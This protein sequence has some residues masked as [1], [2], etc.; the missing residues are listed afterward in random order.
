MK[1]QYCSDLHLEFK[2]NKKFLDRHPVEP[3]GEILLLAGDIVPFPLI[4]QHS[5]FFDSVSANYERVYW[6]PGNH[7]YY[8]YDISK[9]KDQLHEKIRDNV[10][11]VNNNT[12][13][14]KNVNFIFTTLW[15]HIGP[16]NV[17]DIQKNVSD[18]S[19]IRSSG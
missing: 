12:T 2:E 4:D 10:F 6:I 5:V 15:S 18:F 3:V 16:Q 11:L 17:W 1:I 8:H 9:V 14:Y 13:Q 7:E 19:T